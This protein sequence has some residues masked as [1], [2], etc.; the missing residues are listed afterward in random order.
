MY[1][2]NSIPCGENLEKIRNNPKIRPFSFIE[3]S[4]G[5]LLSVEVKISKSKVRK[6]VIKDKKSIR[7]QIEDFCKKY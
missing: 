5:P 6:L 7:S 3:K 4:S 2:N 1:N